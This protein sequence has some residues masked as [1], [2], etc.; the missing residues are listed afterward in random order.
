MRQVRKGARIVFVPGNHDEALR[1]YCGTNFGGIEIVSDAIHETT[2]AAAPQVNG[3]VKTYERLSAELSRLGVSDLFLTPANFRSCA[4]PGYPEIRLAIPNSARLRSWI[5]KLSPDYIHVATEGPIG[6]LTRRVCRREG[7]PLAVD[8]NANHIALNRLKLAAAQYLTQQE[9]YELF[10]D[11]DRKS[12]VALFDTKLV[13]HLD[14]ETAAYWNSLDLRGRRRIEVFAR[15]FYRTGLLGRFITA[16]HAIARLHGVDPSR[17]MQAQTIEE[18]RAM[19]ERDLAPLLKRRAVR[20]MINRPASLFGLGIPPAQYRALV[21][22]L[23]RSSGI[24]A[25][26][27]RTEHRRVTALPDARAIWRAQSERRPRQ[28]PPR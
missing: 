9:F 15:N 25:R 14:R 19:F 24:R 10:G 26:L 23:F 18:Q 11:A 8:L 20:W 21:G 28:H 4:L 7:R 3:V 22:E 6:W 2:D 27:W 17:L 12:N 1:E 13:Q 5:K 16:A